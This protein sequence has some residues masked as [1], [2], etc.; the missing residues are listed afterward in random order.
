M[1]VFKKVKIKKYSKEECM[2]FRKLGKEWASERER[3]N[4]L[5]LKKELS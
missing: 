2:E 5:K 4:F 1:K 3:A